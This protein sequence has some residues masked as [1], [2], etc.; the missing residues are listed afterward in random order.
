M[1]PIEIIVLVFI[2]F[3][4]FLGSVIYA[5]GGKEVL[6]ATLKQ[7]RGKEYVKVERTTD[8][9]PANNKYEFKTIEFE[10]PNG[11]IIYYRGR[12]DLSNNEIVLLSH[13]GTP[14][15]KIRLDEC[16]VSNIKDVLDNKTDFIR[17]KIINNN[18]YEYLNAQLRAKDMQILQ[19]RQEYERLSRAFTELRVKVKEAEN[20]EYRAKYKGL[21]M[22]QPFKLRGKDETAGEFM[23]PI[24]SEDEGEV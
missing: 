11:E 20:R 10:K 9:K 3:A 21:P 5:V 6:D 2:S 17:V 8:I 1:I 7:L 18:A 13:D 4:I 24:I 16:I 22:R 14:I 19:M 23:P 12:Q 15:E